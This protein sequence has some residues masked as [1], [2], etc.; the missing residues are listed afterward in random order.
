MGVH[1]KRELKKSDEWI[2]S[3][4]FFWTHDMVKYWKRT[5]SNRVP[6]TKTAKP[7]GWY[8]PSEYT[9][10][11]MRWNGMMRGEV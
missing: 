6:K 3:L 11:E 4:Y 7:P 10:S 8:T 5:L 9:P 2:L 1:T